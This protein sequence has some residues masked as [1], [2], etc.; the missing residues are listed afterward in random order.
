MPGFLDGIGAILIKVTDWIPGRKE[1]RLND[2]EELEREIKD[3]KNLPCT[4]ATQLKLERL[5]KRLS[6]LKRQ[7]KNS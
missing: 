4:D 6:T 5:T 1:K 7:A 3:I 2:I